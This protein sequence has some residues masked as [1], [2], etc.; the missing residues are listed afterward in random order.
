MLDLNHP[1][2]TLAVRIGMVLSASVF[3]AGR[4]AVAADADP[5]AGKRL[6]PPFDPSLIRGGD[7]L[8]LGSLMSDEGGGMPPGTYR[9]DIIVNGDA[10]G[11]RDIALRQ[12]SGKHRLEPCLSLGMLREF[13]LSKEALARLSADGQ[14]GCVDLSRLDNQAL[15][16]Y[17]SG[18]LL[19]RV[20]VPQV[21]L[22]RNRRGYADESLW[23]YGVNAAFVNYQVNWRSD[24]YGG[25]NVR[26]SY[27]GFSN[28]VNL[29]TWRARN[30]SNLVHTPQGTEFRSN[31]TF[32]QHDVTALRSQFSVGE[33]YSGADLFNSVRFRGVR[34]ES[35]DSML[36]DSER[37]YAPVIRGVAET[38]ATVEVR[39]NGYLLYSATVPPGPFAL[40]E[41]F[42]SGSNGDMH[43]TVIEADGRK[44]E[45]TQAFASVALLVRRGHFKYSAEAGKY[46]SQDDRLS[47]PNFLSA[48]ALY[49]LTDNISVAGGFQ[50]SDSYY[51]LNLGVGANTSIGA[52]SLDATHSRSRMLGET[53]QGQSVR[54][55]Y[56]KTFTETATNFTLAAY[57]YST[58]GY[59]TLD[60]HVSELAAAG[61]GGDPQRYA[62]SLSRSKLD[63]YV[64]QML[65]TGGRWGNFYLNASQQRYWNA[66]SSTSAGAGYG[67]SWRGISYNLSYARTR[68]RYGRSGEARTS[69][70]VM[71]SLSIPLGKSARA[72]SLY[73]SQSRS[74]GSVHSNASVNGYVPGARY[75]M[76]SLQGAHTSHGNNAGS[77]ALHSELP[78]ARIGGTYSAGQGYR[79]LSLHGSGAVVAHG[80]GVNFTRDVGEG[81]VL[82]RVKGVEGVGVGDN[83]PTTGYNSY[84]IYP[85][86]QP[87]R[88]N[89]IHL[90]TDAVGA[91]VELDELVATVVPRRGAIVQADFKGFAGRRV[92]MDFRRDPQ[93]RLPLGA[94]VEDGEGRTVGMVDHRG[95]ALLLLAEDQG[96]LSVKWEGGEC[97]ARYALPPRD[98]AV[99]YDTATVACE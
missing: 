88:I 97:R 50:A 83:L 58:Q 38:H 39:Q 35:D 34:L 77:L 80:G 65:G 63:V 72:P 55:L 79:S 9:L 78:A 15:A 94:M 81:F 76:Y 42:P 91:D 21:F 14:S 25:Q 66:T 26:T 70:T 46:D 49:G 6:I 36:A 16:D 75:T 37:G 60:N 64:N 22:T 84:A 18:R 57:R 19:L 11:K 96:Q 32:L 74:A 82:V 7:N 4:A 73:L 8:D 67:N 59:R 86:I 13:G 23:D 45:F 48:S 12:V 24:R 17:D 93:T 2:R 5:A 54:A 20:T 69:D 61:D 31:R 90:K 30:E 33:L 10:V 99:Y 89:T 52:M 41:F 85:Y 29:G 1:F 44:R 92:Q 47:S 98:P 43:V 3:I 95:R 28:G 87:Y 40:N 56:T 53:R 27:L 71:L 68:D 51:A 62:S